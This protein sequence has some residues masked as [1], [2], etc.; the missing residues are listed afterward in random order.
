VE[1]TLVLAAARRDAERLPDPKAQAWAIHDGLAG[2]LDVVGRK[3]A[4]GA[5]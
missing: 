1:R 3:L 2:V 5:G 4:D